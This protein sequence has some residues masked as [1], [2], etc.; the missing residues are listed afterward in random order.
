MVFL[1]ADGA[2]VHQFLSTGRGATVL[3]TAWEDSDHVL[4][5]LYERGRWAVA[6]L[7]VDGSAE[8]AVAPVEGADLDR[9]FVL[10]QD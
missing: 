1:D 4:A 2:V 10:E 3:Q 5:V 6:R 8:L 7:G 9:P